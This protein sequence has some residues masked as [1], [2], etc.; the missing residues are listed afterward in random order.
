MTL[1]SFC[2]LLL[3]SP[4]LLVLATEKDSP[5]PTPENLV[6][7]LYAAHKADRGPFFQKKDRARVDRF[8]TKALADLIWK[9]ANGPE[10]EVGVLNGD[11]LIDA[12]D[13][14][15]KN[16][17]FHPAK[18]EGSRAKMEVSFELFD[19]PEKVVFHL[20]QVEGKWKISDIL[21]RDGRSLLKDL[22]EGL[23]Q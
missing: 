8:F 21:G 23:A 7:T 22:Q 13:G 16:L 5:T 15:P 10:G 9:D 20:L 6:K 11:P 17:T 14:E 19:K 1:R 18:T 3:A 4:A 12:Q 2:L